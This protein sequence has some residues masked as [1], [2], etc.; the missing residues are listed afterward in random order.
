MRTNWRISANQ[1]NSSKP[2]TIT[3]AQNL[4]YTKTSNLTACYLGKF[5]KPLIGCNNQ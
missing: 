2:Q 5:T 3:Y 1:L 4:H